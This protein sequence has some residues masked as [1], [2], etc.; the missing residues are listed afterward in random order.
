MDRPHTA[1]T[2]I[3]QRLREVEQQIQQS[4]EQHAELLGKLQQYEQTAA[5]QRAELM[6]K[7]DQYQR[8]AAETVKT[9]L[10]RVAEGLQAL[11]NQ[12]DVAIGGLAARMQALEVWA[13]DNRRR[14]ETKEKSTWEGHQT[15]EVDQRGRLEAVEG[16]R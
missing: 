8:S 9:E 15:R 16:G 4:R 14:K 5:E 7:L 3:E 11:Y 1:M 13:A 2:T 12:S 6:M 10:N